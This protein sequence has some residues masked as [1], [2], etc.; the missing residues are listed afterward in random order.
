MGMIVAG[1]VGLALETGAGEGERAGEEE[2]SD[3]SND[4]D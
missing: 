4:A 2:T 3:A 1:A